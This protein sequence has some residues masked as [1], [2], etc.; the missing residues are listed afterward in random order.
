MTLILI[1]RRQDL[2]LLGEVTDLEWVLA[3]TLGGALLEGLL[4]TGPYL[5]WQGL[6]YDSWCLMFWRNLGK[7]E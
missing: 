3:R 4:V 1:V 6:C 5:I 2:M 7:I